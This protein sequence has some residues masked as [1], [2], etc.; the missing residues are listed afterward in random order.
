MV[1]QNDLTCPMHE[2]P[3][4]PENPGMLEDPKALPSPVPNAT[5][6]RPTEVEPTGLLAASRSEPGVADIAR[7]YHFDVHA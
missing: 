7:L 1:L 3:D 4:F 5:P 6:D 2:I